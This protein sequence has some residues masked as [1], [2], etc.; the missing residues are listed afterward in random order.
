MAP[1]NE[2]QRSQLALQPHTRARS[3]PD[4][5]SAQAGKPVSVHTLRH[6]F[7][8]HWLESTT[9]IRTAQDLLGHADGSTTMIYTHGLQVAAGGT[10]SP[11]DALL[12]G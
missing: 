12:T 7:A 5:G 11:L 10:A 2:D 9:N 1:C 4:L 3:K 8:T 6:S